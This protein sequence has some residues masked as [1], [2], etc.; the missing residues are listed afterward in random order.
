MDD[1]NFLGILF[2]DLTGYTALT[3]IHGGYTAF[4]TVDKF[5]KLAQNSLVGKA[6]L[7]EVVG[8]EILITST[9]TEDLLLTVLNMERSGADI[10]NF[11]SLKAGL[12]YG[13]L[14]IIR[15][16]PYGKAVNLASRIIGLASQNE[17]LCSLN[18]LETLN[19]YHT[20]SFED[21]GIFRF[22]NI[23][24]PITVFKLKSNILKRNRL[25]N[26]IDPVC[27]MTLTNTSELDHSAHNNVQYY[28]CSQKCKTL[29]DEN[30]HHFLN[31]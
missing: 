31:P 1:R 26:Q 14:E 13:E 6:T 8:D 19:S 11:L 5:S 29:F 10:S 24:E 22:K 27:K 21:Y 4:T 18:F 17:V 2:V 7:L 9:K 25:L 3:E 23:I 28:F 15:G 12:H 16:K 30:P 20:D